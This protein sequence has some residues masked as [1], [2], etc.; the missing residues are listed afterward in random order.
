MIGNREKIREN[1]RGQKTKNNYG[2]KKKIQSSVRIRKFH[3]SIISKKVLTDVFI[4][5]PTICTYVLLSVVLQK[6]KGK[7]VWRLFLKIIA[8]NL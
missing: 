4:F 6:R 3:N 2:A 7:C 1:V 8:F 5:L